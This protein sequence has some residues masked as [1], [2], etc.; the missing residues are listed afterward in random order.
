VRNFQADHRYADA[1]AGHGFFNGFG[2]GFGEAHNA[3]QH[4]VVEVKEIV[5]FPLG[6]DQGV[7]FGQGANVE[8]RQVFLRF[9]DLVGRNLAA[10]DFAENA[11]HG[12]QFWRTG[13]G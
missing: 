10:D 11:G 4:V 2:D 7:A 1:F 12:M 8:K 13:N 6:N 3:G 5:D 9:G